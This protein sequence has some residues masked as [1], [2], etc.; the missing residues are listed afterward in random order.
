MN[1]LI[2]R[3]CI[4]NIAQLCL[5]CTQHLKRKIVVKVT[6][7]P[8]NFARIRTVKC[9]ESLCQLIIKNK[10]SIKIYLVHS[11]LNRYWEFLA[12]MLTC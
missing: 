1:L 9:I 6:I 11:I 3:N 8:T 10:V 7:S 5:Y 2:I 4:N 12:T